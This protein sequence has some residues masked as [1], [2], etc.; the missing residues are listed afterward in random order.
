MAQ[1]AAAATTATAAST[2]SIVTAAAPSIVTAAAPSPI[3]TITPILK[4][5]NDIYVKASYL[6]RYG[7]SIVF[8]VFAILIVIFY[9]IYLNIQNNKEIVKKDWAI[10]KCNPLY[11]PFAG[12]IIEPKDMTNTEYTIKNFSE[13]SEVILKDIIQIALAPLEAASILI[14][15]STAIL[16]GITTNLMGAISF[17]RVNTMKTETSKV[18]EKQASFSSTLTKVIRQVK[19]ALNKGEG[20]LNTILHIFFSAYKAGASVFYVILLGESIILILMAVG[21]YAAW[22]IWLF[23]ILFVFTIPLAGL[24]LWVPVGLTVIYVAFMIMIIV[25][26]VFTASVIEKTK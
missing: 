20:I 14:S 9:Y 19:S 16:T 26:V 7:G 22:A 17:F 2:P 5:I 15:A 11:M 3:S 25:L 8:V 1:S 12:M 13:C 23:F 6:E 10:N 18:I 24:Y 21:L 4:K